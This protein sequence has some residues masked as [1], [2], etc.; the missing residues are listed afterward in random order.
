MCSG[1]LAATSSRPHTAPSRRC[2]PPSA[3]RTSMGGR[4]EMSTD[5]ETALVRELHQVADGVEVPAMP[6]LPSEP[7]ARSV[8]PPLLVAAAVLL[9]IVG[10]V[11]TVT[12]LGG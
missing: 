2:E 8:W 10:A 4:T 7:R 11:A 9:I 12:T 6:A 3:P 5:L 1:A